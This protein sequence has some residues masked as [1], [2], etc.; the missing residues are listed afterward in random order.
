M[1]IS[2]PENYRLLGFELG[3][4]KHKYIAILENIKTKQKKQVP[5]GGKYP[6]GTPYEQFEDKIGHYKDYDHKDLKRRHNYLKRHEKD[7][8]FKFSSFWFS[9]HFLW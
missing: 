2:N 9:K 4:K 1:K 3:G 5:F 6:D 7:G 8:D